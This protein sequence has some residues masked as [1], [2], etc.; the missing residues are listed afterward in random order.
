M[1]HPRSAELCLELL[2]VLVVPLPHVNI[3]V[4]ITYEGDNGVQV[5]VAAP[6]TVRLQCFTIRV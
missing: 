5:Q 4:P 6:Y 2:V 1:M 3:L